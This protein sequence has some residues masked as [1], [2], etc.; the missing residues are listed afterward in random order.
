[1][2]QKC[3]GISH[4]SQRIKAGWFKKVQAV[5]FHWAPSSSSVSWIFG[6]L[7]VDLWSVRKQKNYFRSKTS[8]SHKLLPILNTT[9]TAQ[10]QALLVNQMK[11][12][13]ETDTHAWP[14]PTS[15]KQVLLCWGIAT[16]IWCNHLVIS[17]KGKKA[18]FSPN[19]SW[20]KGKSIHMVTDSKDSHNVTWDCEKVSYYN[21]ILTVNLSLIKVR[22]SFP[23][24]VIF[25]ILFSIRHESFC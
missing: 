7:M 12:L 15:I 13:A 9:C 22:V 10:H 3:L 11:H 1:M 16:W 4:C 5:Q 21:T 23:T 24:E 14:S 8:Q 2:A 19:Y 6:V 20:R 25:T 17:L 18:S